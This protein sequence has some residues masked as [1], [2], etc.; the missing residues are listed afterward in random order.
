MEFLR[1]SKIII[2]ASGPFLKIGNFQKITKHAL[3][4]LFLICGTRGNSFFDDIRK[5]KAGETMN[6]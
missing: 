4:F 2:D 6:C 1:I 5:E 3:V